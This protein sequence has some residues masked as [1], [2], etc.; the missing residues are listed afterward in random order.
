MRHVTC[1]LALVLCVVA[2]AASVMAQ[3]DAAP[4]VPPQRLHD[5]GD[6]VIEKGAE[7]AAENGTATAPAAAPAT[8]TAT[9]TAAPAP[10]MVPMQPAR[11]PAPAPTPTPATTE[12]APAETPV[13]TSAVE[14]T[15]NLAARDIETPTTTQPAGVSEQVPT[16]SV[17]QMHAA[18]PAVVPAE[19]APAVEP[20]PAMATKPYEVQVPPARP[21]SAATS[22]VMAVERV[23]VAR[24]TY[25]LALE[26][27][28]QFYVSNGNATKLEWVSKELMG[29]N[30][31]EQYHYL[32]EMELAGPNLRPTDSIP[33]ADQLYQ[34]GLDFKNYPAFPDEKREKLKVAVQKF[35]TIISDY[36]RSDKIDDAAYMLGEIYEGWYYNDFSRA[37]LAFERCFQ[38]NPKTILPARIKAAR[39]YDQKLMQRDKAVVLY[40]LVIS[41]STN[42]EH[43]REAAQ[44][45]NQLAPRP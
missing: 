22:E 31:I 36:P 24:E 13:E 5:M 30:S 4:P 35:R 16:P 17:S 29:L 20:A 39:L 28:K 11:V 26:S 37:A 44:R 41:E 14:S 45:L 7:V 6:V 2:L 40:N 18:T 3:T 34:E 33:A 9:P 21:V 19:A 1:P 25:R 43:R 12:T 15:R 32:S 10:D 27:L 38:W 8:E 23:A 42:E